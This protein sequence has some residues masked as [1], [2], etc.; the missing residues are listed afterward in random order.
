MKKQRDELLYDSRNVAFDTV[1]KGENTVPNGQLQP[2]L[3]AKM[4]LI[5]R[6][7]EV[8]ASVIATLD[9]IFGK[10]HVN[11]IETMASFA[12]NHAVKNGPLQ[13]PCL[14]VQL[15]MRLI[16]K[17]APRVNDRSYQ[18]NTLS[19]LNTSAMRAS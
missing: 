10:S 2:V 8:D 14:T 11:L 15:K 12:E 5:V 13:F 16:T 17:P 19:K 6:E 1:E 18:Q 7:P 9:Q 3:F 4:T